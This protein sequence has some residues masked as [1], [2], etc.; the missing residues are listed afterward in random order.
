M[1]GAALGG[2]IASHFGVTGPFW[3][4]FGGSGVFVVLMWRQVSRIAHEES[5]SVT[6]PSA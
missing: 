5:P 2:T 3:F 4:A 6:A 1:V